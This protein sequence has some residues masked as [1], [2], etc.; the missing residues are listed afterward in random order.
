MACDNYGCSTAITSTAGPKGD[1]GA[2]GASGTATATVV[3]ATDITYTLAATATGTEYYMS[4]DAGT[5]FTLPISPAVGTNFTFVTRATPTTGSFIINTGAGDFYIGYVYSHK[6]AAD[7]IVYTANAALTDTHLTLNGS[8]T[9]G[10]I[11]TKITVTYIDATNNLW[12]VTGDT[13]A[14]GA[15][16]TPFS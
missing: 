6:S 10:V 11:G 1:T 15:Q 9:G 3:L 5:V 2:T 13:L 4:R 14:T 12:Y 7:E 16:A 8:T